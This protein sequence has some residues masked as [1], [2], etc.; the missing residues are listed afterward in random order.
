MFLVLILNSKS[1]NFCF[2]SFKLE[3]FEKKNFLDIIKIVE[4]TLNSCE[5]K[6]I[7][8]LADLIS[9]DKESRIIAA[10]RVTECAVKGGN[11]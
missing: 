3:S 2:D 4:S 10:E 9:A 11:S 5:A 7:S 1:A 6:E 8:A